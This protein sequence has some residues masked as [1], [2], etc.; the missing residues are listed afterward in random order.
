MRPSRT[1]VAGTTVA[2]LLAISPA[3]PASA[4][5]I[6]TPFFI[7]R[8][9][10]VTPQCRDH[11]DAPFVGRVSGWMSGGPNRSVSFVGCF[12]S[13]PECESWRL[14]VSGQILGHLIQNRCEVRR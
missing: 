1:A 7:T 13:A 4:Q 12:P 9:E 8:I 5:G 3:G 14:F 11:P 2:V 6:E 10:G